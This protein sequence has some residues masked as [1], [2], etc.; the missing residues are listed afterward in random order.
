[1]HPTRRLQLPRR[2]NQMVALSNNKFRVEQDSRRKDASLVA[3]R[4]NCL[5]KKPIHSMRRRWRKSMRREKGELESGNLLAESNIVSA[6]KRQ[7]GLHEALDVRS[8]SG[9]RDWDEDMN[10]RAEFRQTTW[11]YLNRKMRPRM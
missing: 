11:S 1:M 7:T 2:R 6:R 10:C 8:N 9:D 5:T 4:R 3:S